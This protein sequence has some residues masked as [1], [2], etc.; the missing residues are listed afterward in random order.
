MNKQTFTNTTLPDEDF[1]DGYRFIMLTARGK[2]GG[3]KSKPDRIAKRVISKN[4]EEFIKLY[5]DLLA[6]KKPDER[7]YSCVNKR[8]INKA[9]RLFK[10]RQLDADYYDKESKTGFYLDIKNRWLGAM[11]CPQSRVETKFLIDVDNIIGDKSDIS[12]VDK[13][14]K[15]IKVKVLLKYRTKNGWHIITKPFNPALYDSRFGDIH[16]DA[17]LL[18]SY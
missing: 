12:I 5:N 9:I 7:I 15:D 1:M 16:K 10:Q 11:M 13:H 17:L 14:L 2:E 3:K 4:K 6:I 8:D 18:L